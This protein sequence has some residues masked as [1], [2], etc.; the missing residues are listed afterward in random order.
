MKPARTTGN[1]RRRAHRRVGVLYCRHEHITL[2]DGVRRRPARSR[3]PPGRSPRSPTPS[4]RSP[5]RGSS[6]APA[7]RRRGRDAARP[8]RPHRRRRPRGARAHPVG[9]GARVARRQD[10]DSGARQRA[11]P[12][13]RHRRPRGQGRYSAANVDAR[14]A[15]STPPTASPR[16]SASAAIRPPSFAARDAQRTPSLDRARI[17]V[18]GPV[19]APKTPQDARRLVD[20]DAAIEGRHRQ[21][22]RGR[23]PRH[24]AEDDARDLPRGH[25]PGA[26]GRPARRRA[27]L[28]PRRTRRRVLDAGADFIAHSVRDTDVDADF[29]AKMK[30]RKVCYC[31]TLM[32]EVSTFVYGSTPAFFSDPFFLKHADMARRQSARG[33]DAPGRRCASSRAAQRVQGGAGG[34]RAESQEAVRRRRHDRHGHRFGSA[35]ALPG[36]LRAARA[37]DDGRSPA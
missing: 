10:G 35:R 6:T 14:S 7:A 27:P 20:E 26:Q 36:L 11:R 29:I 15:A 16:S 8:R 12:R 34:G 24:D 19:L 25:R 1:V 31:P 30:A 18:A 32:R 23:Q 4:R 33:S 13:R 5:A 22:P 2:R 9:R 28:L 17:F 21:D 3:R 37:R